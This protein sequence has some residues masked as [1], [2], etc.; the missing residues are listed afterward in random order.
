MAD[1]RIW[2]PIQVGRTKLS[3]RIVM[4]PLTRNRNDDEHVPMDIMTEYYA[5]RACVPGTLIITEATGVSSASE[6]EIGLPVVSTPEQVEGWRKIYE[7]VHAKGSFVYQQLWDLGRGAD[8]EYQRER[9]HKYISSSNVKLEKESI[10]PEA[11]TEDEIW[12]KIAQ[13]RKAARNVIDAG[14]DGVEIHGA[15]GY[16]IDQFTRDSVNKRTDHWG[17]SVENRSRFLLEIVKAVVEEI[18]AD[19]TA[20]RLSPFGTYQHCFSSDTWEQTTHVLGSI[21]A[22]GYKLAY[23]SLVEP[24]FDPALYGKVPPPGHPMPFE[25]GEQSLIFILKEWDNFSPVVVAGGY[26]A[27]TA[28]EALGGKYSGWD[29]II[30]FGRPYVANPDLVF[31]VKNT[32][33]FNAYD[34]PTFFVHKSPVGYIDYPFSKEAI[35]A[36]LAKA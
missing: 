3:H 28:V 6:G 1:H 30:A 22:N 11:M 16:L 8:P 27:E 17:G 21:K 10:A 34:R 26:S 12:E 13:F 23:L 15:H 9:G 5:Q 29:V 24:R 18:G 7:A 20:L 14:G 36:G 4:A 35:A 32:L 33:A 31:R 19:R 2:H 25:A